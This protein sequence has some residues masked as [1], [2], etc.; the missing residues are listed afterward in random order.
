LGKA[1]ESITPQIEI[2]KRICK[3][4]QVKLLVVL[5]PTKLDVE[6]HTDR[7]RIMAANE[8]LR[9]SEGDLGINRRFTESVVSWLSKEKINHID[10]FSPMKKSI[11]QLFWT[12]DHHLNNRGHKKVARIIYNSPY[13]SIFE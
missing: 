12:V 11:R 13:R 3:D 7:E 8:I 6:M 1:V 4:N 5:L 2:I 10:L 9:L